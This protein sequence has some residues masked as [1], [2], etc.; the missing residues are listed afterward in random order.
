MLA[1]DAETVVRALIAYGC[2]DPLALAHDA[3]EHQTGL[4]ARPDAPPLSSEEALLW[5]GGPRPLFNAL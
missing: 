2:L 1:A 4:C 3:A 5:C